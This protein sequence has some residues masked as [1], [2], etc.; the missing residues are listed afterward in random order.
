MNHFKFWKRIWPI[1]ADYFRLYLDNSWSF[2]M[3]KIER[4]AHSWTDSIWWPSTTSCFISDRFDYVLLLVPDISGRVSEAED[5][6]LSLSLIKFKRKSWLH[7]HHIT[8]HPHPLFS[9]PV[10]IDASRSNRCGRTGSR[11]RNSTCKRPRPYGRFSVNETA[12]EFGSSLVDE[13]ALWRLVDSQNCRVAWTCSVKPVK[14]SVSQSPPRRLK[15][16]TNQS[17]K[18]PY[19]EPHITVNGQ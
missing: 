7:P 2:L 8:S 16:F 10:A 17:D 1:K 5:A 19:T 12:L 6:Q 4:L 18:A 9:S 14:I 3:L 11:S 13:A 15:S